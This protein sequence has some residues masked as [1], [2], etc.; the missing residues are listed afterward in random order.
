MES[1]RKLSQEHKLHIPRKPNAYIRELKRG[2][3]KRVKKK[4]KEEGTAGI[5]YQGF[6]YSAFNILL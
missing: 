4:R 6:R 5:R 3:E 2:K 1:H